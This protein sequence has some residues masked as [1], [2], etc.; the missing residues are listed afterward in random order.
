MDLTTPDAMSFWDIRHDQWQSEVQ[1]KMI[2][3]KVKEEGHAISKQ[4]E[5]PKY[6][7]GTCLIYN[8]CLLYKK[9]QLLPVGL[10]SLLAWDI[11]LRNYTVTNQVIILKRSP[12][13]ENGG[14]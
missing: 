7:N 5:D 14:I 8:V 3:S 11:N 6:A 2:F 10:L 4:T 9:I 1:N 13:D 12:L